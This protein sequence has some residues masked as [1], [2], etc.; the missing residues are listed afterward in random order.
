MF[1]W[2]NRSSMHMPPYLTL[3]IAL[4]SSALA[5]F[6]LSLQNV[7]RFWKK[8][9]SCCL[10]TT[11]SRNGSATS[12]VDAYFTHH[13]LSIPLFG[14]SAYGQRHLPVMW[15][16]QEDWIITKYL[17]CTGSRLW[18]KTWLAWLYHLWRSWCTAT[19]SHLFTRA[20]YYTWSLWKL[21]RN[22]Q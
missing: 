5:E 13:L 4:A 21:Q 20:C 19:F 14:Y 1:R 11:H 6:L 9:V 22:H 15:Q 17:W 3:M 12:C 7:V 8:K 18:S 16:C 10:C 2:R